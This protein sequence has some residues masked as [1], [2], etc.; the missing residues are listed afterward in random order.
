VQG[1]D[2]LNE[3]AG[4]LS[5]APPPLPVPGPLVDPPYCLVA[6]AQEARNE[7]FGCLFCASIVP[8]A[9][10]SASCH[11]TTQHSR[12]SLCGPRAYAAATPCSP[13][14]SPPTTSNRAVSTAIPCPSDARY[15]HTCPPLPQDTP[16]YQSSSTVYT[17][18]EYKNN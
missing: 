7:L 2:P 12:C 13:L 17:Y 5:F 18:N 8:A 3:H 15:L 16:T 10:A 6:R 1:R 9:S 4:A 14:P 11:V